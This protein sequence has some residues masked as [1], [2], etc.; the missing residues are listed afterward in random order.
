MS[1]GK[2]RHRAQEQPIGCGIAKTPG[3][4]SGVLS[5]NSLGR[6]DQPIHLIP[7]FPIS[8]QFS[9]RVLHSWCHVFS[10]FSTRFSTRFNNKRKDTER[11]TRH[12]STPS[13][14]GAPQQSLAPPQRPRHVTNLS[15]RSD[16]FSKTRPPSPVCYRAPHRRFRQCQQC[17]FLLVFLISYTASL[18]SLFLY[19]SSGNVFS[20]LF[21]MCYLG[22]VRNLATCVDVRTGQRMDQTEVGYVCG[23]M[24][25]GQLSLIKV[26]IKA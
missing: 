6:S 5:D 3:S 20:Y 9:F 15:A 19:A 24:L 11:D 12:L 17:G 23:R 1:G 16:T 25:R 22:C 18:G 14:H 4:G 13:C 21:W 26:Q 10:R 8:F 7:R 2:Q